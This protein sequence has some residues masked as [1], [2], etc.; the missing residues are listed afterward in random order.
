MVSFCGEHP[1]MLIQEVFFFILKAA[2]MLLKRFG[3]A[4]NPHFEVPSSD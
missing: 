4:M 1:H 2:Y 3:G